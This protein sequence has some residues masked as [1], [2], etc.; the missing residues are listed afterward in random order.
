MALQTGIRFVSAV[1]R[2]L[3]LVPYWV[4]V[5]ALLSKGAIIKDRADIGKFALSG[6]CRRLDTG[7]GPEYLD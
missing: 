1:V 5:A 4:E 6:R 7:V 2:L 3:S